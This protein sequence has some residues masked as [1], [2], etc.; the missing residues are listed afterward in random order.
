MRA[1]VPPR[2]DTSTVFPVDSCARR[3]DGVLSRICFF[4]FLYKHCLVSFIN[5]ACP[6]WSP[7]RGIASPRSISAFRAP[8]ESIEKFRPGGAS[9]RSRAP[10]E[11]A[12]SST[13]PRSPAL[14]LQR[15]LHDGFRT[16]ARPSLA[17]PPFIRNIYPREKS[18]WMH[19]PPVRVCSRDRND[20]A[21]RVASPSSAMKFHLVTC[22]SIDTRHV[23]T[24]LTVCC[25]AGRG[26]MALVRAHRSR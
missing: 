11:R 10:R 18:A 6:S 22:V 14:G 16:H 9:H 20:R 19:F 7:C 12:A 3:Y 23:D 21:T 2:T 26:E 13:G 4:L 24:R 8:L 25:R 15:P 5:V 17:L 1:C